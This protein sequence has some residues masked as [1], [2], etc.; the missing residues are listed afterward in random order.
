MPSVTARDVIQKGFRLLSARD[1]DA[2]L[3]MFTDDVCLYDL[4]DLP[5]ADSYEG[6]DGLRRWAESNMA[7]S[8][9]WDWHLVEVLADEGDLAIT[10]VELTGRA[11]T[12]DVPVRLQV[13]HV[14]EIEGDK[15]DS[16]RAFA[17]RD[18]AFDA[19]GLEDAGV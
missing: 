12:S 1:L 15:I 10:E 2:W 8:E 7:L 19:A 3:E 14:F 5:D 11:I 9:E 6:H 4:P 18:Q 13:F 17:T 16:V